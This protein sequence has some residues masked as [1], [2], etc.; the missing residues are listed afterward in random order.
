MVAP[1]ID[2]AFDAEVT[3]ENLRDCNH[4]KAGRL[5]DAGEYGSV[6]STDYRYCPDCGALSYQDGPFV[7]PNL[8]R[9]E[10]AR[11]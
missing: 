8:I 5:L 4:A 7:L 1:L 6:H 10:E 3:L 11:I 9:P 2:A